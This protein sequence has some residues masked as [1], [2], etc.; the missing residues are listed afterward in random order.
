MQEGQREARRDEMR[1]NFADETRISKY[2]HETCNSNVQTG[3]A[4]ASVSYIPG[5]R[6]EGYLGMTRA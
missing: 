4:R 1:E 3:V 6:E 2:I 5:G